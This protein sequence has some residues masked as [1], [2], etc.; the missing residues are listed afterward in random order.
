MRGAT[1]NLKGTTIGGV[2]VD[3]DIQ[4]RTLDHTPSIVLAPTPAATTKAPVQVPA[5][6][7]IAQSSS[8][9]DVTSSAD[10]SKPR[11]AP[12]ENSQVRQRIAA[13]GVGFWTGW[14]DVICM[15][16]FSC[17]SSKITGAIH[18]AAKG[19][20]LMTWFDVAFTGSGIAL[21][22]LGIT[23]QRMVDTRVNHRGKTASASLLSPIILSLFL[24]A[25]LLG[26]VLGVWSFLPLCFA[27]GLVNNSVLDVTGT[28]TCAVTGHARTIGVELADRIKG[29][30]GAIPNPM[31][32][33]VFT[34][35]AF[36]AGAVCASVA[37]VRFG[38]P[39]WHA[40]AG[41]MLAGLLAWMDW[42]FYSWRQPRATAPA[43]V[44]SSEVE[45]KT[46]STP[47]LATA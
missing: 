12:I 44:A 16:S 30:R 28:I 11:V 36:V 24:A 14:A 22:T 33:A 40:P 4:H 27:F 45:I 43:E 1:T 7:P 21:Y 20:A 8:S 35:T 9:A 6:Q 15:S 46:S 13:A 39:S 31:Y 38:L 25:D 34:L 41:L 42:P 10:V 23:A 26:G 19:L 5:S 17:F 18:R 3:S 32:K 47:T 2:E 29:K 37:T